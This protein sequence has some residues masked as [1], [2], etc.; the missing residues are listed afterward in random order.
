MFS[1]FGRSMAQPA[2]A[3]VLLEASRQATSGQ[4]L[5]DEHITPP[6]ASR[7]RPA[8]WVPLALPAH[9]SPQP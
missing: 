7:Q 4:F 3:L 8:D 6:V 2:P 5:L 1:S 9:S